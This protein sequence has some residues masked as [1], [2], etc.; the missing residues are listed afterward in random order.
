MRRYEQGDHRDQRPGGA[1]TLRVD[2]GPY[3]VKQRLRRS[4]PRRAQSSPR[5]GCSLAPKTALLVP[6]LVTVCPVFELESLFE[7]A[8]AHS[9]WFFALRP[10]RR[11]PAEFLS[12]IGK[13]VR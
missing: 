2:P 4:S 11:L 7:S 13:R 9:Q 5:G 12:T 10:F 8:W 1:H 3:R 6:R